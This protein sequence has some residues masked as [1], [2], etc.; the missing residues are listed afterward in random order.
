MLNSI[1]IRQASIYFFLIFFAANSYAQNYKSVDS[2]KSVLLSEKREDTNTVNNYRDLAAHYQFNK[3]DSGIYYANKALLLSVKLRFT[4]GEFRSLYT[5]AGALSVI[6]SDSAAVSC[7]Y[8]LLK[9]AEIKKDRSHFMRAYFAMA[10]VY[11]FIGE[12]N[13]S[14]FYHRKVLTYLSKTDTLLYYGCTEHFAES[15]A[16]LKQADSTFYYAKKTLALDKRGANINPFDLYLMGYAYFLKNKYVDALKYYKE[17]LHTRVKPVSKVLSDC[18][19]G[20]ATVFQK[21]GM[22]DSAI[23]YARI[24]FKI[25][26]N[27][28]I[29]NE[30]LETLTL[31]TTLFE[32][33][34]NIDSAYLYQKYTSLLKD[35]INS[36]DKI[37]E[38][39]MIAFNDRMDKQVELE[40]QSKII[41][42]IIIYSLIGALIFSLVIG[43]II[44]RNTR[45]RKQAYKLL[46]QQQQEIV[47]QKTK[48]ENTLGDLRA[49]QTLLIQSEKMASLGEL[50]AGI[51]HEIQNPLNFVNNFSEVSVELL[52]EL[53]E[54]EE[55]GNKEDV[56]AIADDL[57]Q[58]LEKIRHHGKRADAIVKG[59]LEHSRASIGQKEPTDINA[60]ADEYLRLAY[61]GLRAK[62]KSFNAELVTNFDKNLPKINVIPQD[63][64][65]VLLNL[66]NNAF[67]AVNQKAKTD[68]TDYKPQITVS[69][70]LQNNQVVIGV[71]DNGNGIPNAIKDKIMQPFFTTKPTGE[72]TGLGLSLSYDIVVKGYGGTINVETRENEFTSFIIQLPLT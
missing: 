1:Y 45:Q 20:V 7:A 5:K 24:A 30:K 63:I 58:N 8:R 40:Q 68:F 53:K 17:A 9:M 27:N 71:K 32:A 67:Y 36:L 46:Q 16:G 25:A 19:F 65:R 4:E 22:P 62:D 66:F 34:A 31:L 52:A 44:L 23:S 3:P 61:H 28:G 38:V 64:C 60:L 49:T 6:R 13:K 48:V 12:Y 42:R 11:M 57:T 15:F 41:D 37:R 50:T 70:H 43:F 33:K 39:Q 51:A 47:E 35:S 26:A 69:T 55:K 72:G 14:I 59:M 18:N 10:S 2:L 29:P 56:I 21:R 54:E